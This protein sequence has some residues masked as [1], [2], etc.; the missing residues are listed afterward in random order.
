LLRRMTPMLEKYHA[1]SR[2]RTDT[3]ALAPGS[4]R[5]V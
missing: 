1:A 4:G 5:G 2:V 3:C